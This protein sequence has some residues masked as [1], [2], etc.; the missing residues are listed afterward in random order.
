MEFGS[1]H[2]TAALG[3]C[4]ASGAASAT[5]IE[6]QVRHLGASYS[7]TGV[8]VVAPPGAAA[9][10][11]PIGT[12]GPRRVPVRS[13][14]AFR[15][16]SVSKVINATA[17]AVHSRAGKMSLDRDIRNQAEW[18]ARRAGAQPVTLRQLLT[19]TSGFEDRV[20]GSFAHNPAEVFPFG[21]YLERNLAARTTPPDKWTRYSNQGASLAGWLA[22]QHQG[23]AYAKFI[24][25]TLF[26]RLG[27]KQSSFSQPL[28]RDLRDRLALVYPCA[29][30]RC[31]PNP[32]Q[33]RQTPPAGA[34]VTTGDDMAL[35]VDALVA[36]REGPLGDASDI[37]LTRSW[38]PSRQLP[39][40]ALALQEQEIGGHR[41]LVH[42][43]GSEGYRA[44]LALVPD[45]RSAIFAVVTAGD[46]RFGAELVALFS[47][48]Q[49]RRAPH[50]IPSWLLPVSA[51][52]LPS[53]SRED[54]EGYYLL[55]RGSLAGE[56]QLPGLF[57][58]GE[59]FGFDG[60]G[61]LVRDEGGSVVQYGRV[62]GDL[63]AERNGSGRI[64]FVRDGHGRIAGVHAPESFF[65]IEYPASYLRLPG[66]KSPPV[67]NELLSWSLGVPPIALLI[68]GFA[69]G[70]LA[71]CRR[72]RSYSQPVPIAGAP[73][74][75]AAL[76]T[77]AA[78]AVGFGFVA[79]FVA[80]ATSDPAVLATGMPDRLS[81][82]RLLAVPTIL[83]TAISIVLTIIQATRSCQKRVLD[84]LALFVTNASL[85]IFCGMLVYFELA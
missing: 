54:Y 52:P 56:E 34:L 65:G 10:V 4:A 43:G 62:K 16:A 35:F 8:V 74:A 6:D 85:A 3:L 41:A 24:E 75:T 68:W 37:L 1:W 31:R 67:V 32:L 69:T 57:A 53:R 7:V 23:Q 25:T 20:V 64:L 39:G 40:L 2:I 51:R 76:A 29:D 14:T 27:M 80:L 61:W 66:W 55:G 38:G 71:L 84:F 18:L 9:R 30:F 11:I 63:F 17:I 49:S 44:L 33:Y 28:P 42:A 60:D 47:N 26:G 73:L 46:S 58:F 36:G 45:T 22:A 59:H 82:Y 12:T 48:M 72:R 50:V 15:V 70:G 81:N 78:L 21:S 13:D 19:H 79:A 83:L 77:A 5:P